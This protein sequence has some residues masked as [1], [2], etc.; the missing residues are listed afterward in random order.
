[1]KFSCALDTLFVRCLMPPCASKEEYEQRWAVFYCGEPKARSFGWK[2]EIAASMERH[3]KLLW[4]NV[5]PG[6][7]HDGH[8]AA[9]PNGFFSHLIPGETVLT[10]GASTYL[11]SPFC[12]A[13]PHKGMNSY[14]E[15]LDKVELS[16]QRNVERVNKLVEDWKILHDVFRM[17]PAQDLF[18]AKC[19]AVSSAVCKLISIDQLLSAG[20]K[21]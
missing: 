4:F 3:P 5:A 11:S 14:V 2:I 18:W 8:L 20:E 9:L 6:S 16:L 12:V 10:D 19:T 17:S 1:M 7:V 13:P 21:Y 15:E